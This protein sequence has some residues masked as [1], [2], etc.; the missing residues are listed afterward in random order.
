M[1]I[2]GNVGGQGKY[3]EEDFFNI[4]ISLM[5]TPKINLKNLTFC[6]DVYL[7]NIRLT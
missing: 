7:V 4:L 6:K 1:Q 5:P 2:L 3:N